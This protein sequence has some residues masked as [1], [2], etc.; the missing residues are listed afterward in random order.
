ML[1]FQ[2]RPKLRNATHWTTSVS[3]KRVELHD[4]QTRQLCTANK[5]SY[6]YWNHLHAQEVRRFH[7]HHQFS[8]FASLQQQGLLRGRT[9]Q[10]LEFRL[11]PGAL[12]KQKPVDYNSGYAADYENLTDEEFRRLTFENNVPSIPLPDRSTISMSFKNPLANPASQSDEVALTLTESTVPVV[13]TR[14]VAEDSS[15]AIVT[16]SQQAL[17]YMFSGF[18]SLDDGLKEITA[19]LLPQSITPASFT[20]HFADGSSNCL[21]VVPGYRNFVV[22]AGHYF[23]V[24]NKVSDVMQEL[25][26][27]APFV[28]SVFRSRHISLFF[29]E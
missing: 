18:T 15:S 9:I 19:P 28:D 6:N 1:R 4:W 11:F 2:T 21:E 7:H 23:I 27:Q 16:I 26:N 14:N 25:L 29:K 8:T 5:T 20:L 17:S 10:T 12:L 3:P 22:C 24:S 13:L